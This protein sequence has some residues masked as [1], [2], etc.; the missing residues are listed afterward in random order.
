MGF[1][2][3]ISVLKENSGGSRNLLKEGFSYAIKVVFLC[4]LRFMTFHILDQHFPVNLE[5]PYIDT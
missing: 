5:K 3:V 2:K 4:C 1:D